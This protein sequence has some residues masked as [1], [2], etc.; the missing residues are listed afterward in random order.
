[1]YYLSKIIFLVVT[2]LFVFTGCS[3]NSTDELPTRNVRILLGSVGIRYATYVEFVE[4]NIINFVLFGRSSSLSYSSA[5]FDMA[6]LDDFISSSSYMESSMFFHRINW[7]NAAII[8]E[9]TLEL[10]EDQLSYIG[11]LI[12]NVARQRA[13][14]EFEPIL[15]PGHRPYIWAI[16]DDNMYWSLYTPDVSQQPRQVRRRYTNSN[17]LQ[18]AYELIDLSPHPV[19]AEH[20]FRTPSSRSQ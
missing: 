17:L 19:G 18:L 6:L 7:D 15:S 4:P 5:D 11:N 20:S 9:W 3:S 14:R 12:E 2:M 10:S 1:M 13:S 8:D 16:I